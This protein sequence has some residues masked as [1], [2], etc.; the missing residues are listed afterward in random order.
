MID[1]NAGPLLRQG[2]TCWRIERAGRLAVIVDAADYF[3]AVRT[4]VQNARHSVFL[5]G[6]DFDTR[7]K[8]VRPGDGSKAPNK[9]SKFLTWVVR[10]R[11]DLR[12]YVLR[13][14]LGAIHALGRGSTPLVILDWMSNERIRFKLDG[15]H[16]PGSAHHQ[17]IV[18]IDDAFAF[19]GGIDMTGDRWD[20]REHLDDNPERVRPTTRRR[21]GP[22]HDVSIAVDGEA[23]RALGELA[24]ERWKHA[25]G[26][27]LEPPPPMESAWP[28]G[29]EP[30]FRDVDVAVS[31]TAPEYDDRRGVH[32]IEALY[33]DAIA[34]AKRTIYIESQYFASR[35]IAEAMATRLHEADGPEIVVINPESLDGWLE[36]AVMG[37]ARARLLRVVREADRDGRFRLYTP[38][39]AGGR[40]IYVH[41]KVMVVDARLLKVGSS[42]LNNRSLGFD[43]ECDLSVEARPDAADGSLGRS[44]VGLRNDLLAEHLGVENAVLEQVIERA[45]GSLIPAIEELRSEGRSLVPLEMP[46]INAAEASLM[47]EDQLLDPERP[48][49]RWSSL[50]RG[51][52]RLMSTTRK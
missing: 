9:L 22:W 15:A 51:L 25:T 52:R 10:Q 46:E 35:K 32:E 24:R 7:I 47:E 37:S 4:A 49:S 17:K 41:A 28:V 39:T 13:W 16:P 29:L 36:E 31:R 23:A 26:E 1:G 40:P 20:T 33:L 11:P 30:T 44:I 6:W 34:A 48:S 50:R 3:A 14:D 5:I 19:C 42:N 2:E 12:I 18:A 45:G 21:Y 27:D 8:L 38:V 43:T